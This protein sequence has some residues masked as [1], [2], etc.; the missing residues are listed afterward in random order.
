M[1]QW[2]FSITSLIRSSSDRRAS[3]DNHAHRWQGCTA[4]NQS[5]DRSTKHYFSCAEKL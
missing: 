3:T 1:F 4:I 2:R 5:I